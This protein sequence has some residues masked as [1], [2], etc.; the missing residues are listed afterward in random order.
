MVALKFHFNHHKIV[1]MLAIETVLI[2]THKIHVTMS[3]PSKYNGKNIFHAICHHILKGFC[4]SGFCW[5]WTWQPGYFSMYCPPLFF[6]YE[7]ISCTQLIMLLIHGNCTLSIGTVTCPQ[8]MT[9]TIMVVVAITLH[10]GQKDTPVFPFHVLHPSR[11][12]V[13]ILGYQK[14][15]G[16]ARGGLGA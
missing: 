5:F 7:L 1:L 8:Y 12:L 10:S 16:I 15:R 4:S 6:L 9:V 3:K 14:N 13:G 11:M 2:N